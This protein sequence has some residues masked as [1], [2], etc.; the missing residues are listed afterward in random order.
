MKISLAK[1]DDLS[2]TLKEKT[3]L[4]QNSLDKALS[5]QK[6]FGNSDD[7]LEKEL[8]DLKRDYDLLK[9]ENKRLEAESQGLLALKYKISDYEDVLK[10]KSRDSLCIEAEYKKEIALM[11][12]K[13]DFAE[14]NNEELTKKNKE[15]YNEMKALKSQHYNEIKE[16][17]LKYEAVNKSLDIEL[18]QNKDRVHD[19]QLE[20][21]ASSVKLYK[22]KE[23]FNL[24]ENH[25]KSIIQENNENLRD[26]RRELQDLSNK[27]REKSEKLKNLHEKTLEEL[28]ESLKNSEEA[29][30]IKE[31]AYKELKITYEKDKAVLGQKI[32]FLELELKEFKEKKDESTNIQNAFMKAL[33]LS[34]NYSRTSKSDE[35]TDKIKQ[36]I[37]HL[38]EENRS[39]KARNE[40]KDREIEDLRRFKIR[41]SDEIKKL[42][43]QIMDLR[44]H[45]ERIRLEASDSQA[46][47][48]L[49]IEKLIALKETL[50][51]ECN[52]VREKYSKDQKIWGDKLRLISDELRDS[53]RKFHLALRIKEE[54]RDYMSCE[55]AHNNQNLE[56][57]KKKSF[58]NC[59]CQENIRKTPMST[60]SSLNSLTNI[61]DIPVKKEKNIK[62]EANNNYDIIDLEKEGLKNRIYELEQA[63]NN[64]EARREIQKNELKREKLKINPNENRPENKILRKS[65]NIYNTLQNP[66]TTPKGIVNHSVSTMRGGR[67]PYIKE[68]LAVATSMKKFSFHSKK[69]SFTEKSFL[70]LNEANNNNNKLTIADLTTNKFSNYAERSFVL[71]QWNSSSLEEHDIFDKNK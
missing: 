64:S 39:L 2:T 24:S 30:K 31:K 7:M 32:E 25:Y 54:E 40:S 57:S 6:T 49:E 19:L 51:A 23:N 50:E 46:L 29:C 36:E 18:K 42:Q 56:I 59:Q 60:L 27:D 48:T 3:T 69:P 26:L 20:L 45:N 68:N 62:V 58:L 1:S 9:L 16:I 13:L 44:T 28:N 67:S 15:H 70:N 35:L 22:E 55:R 41:D 52:E 8:K 47:L 43:N 37:K 65:V 63:L 66:L 21:E 11:R 5:E 71:N 53:E 61:L 10:G 33:E 17:T 34:D 4:I 14:K 12:Q 38:E